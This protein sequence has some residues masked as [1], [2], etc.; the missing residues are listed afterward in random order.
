MRY[1]HP[2]VKAGYLVA[3]PVILLGGLVVWGWGEFCR[4]LTDALR[5]GEVTV[6]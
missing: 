2:L 4:T 6:K 3:A 5:W 1:S